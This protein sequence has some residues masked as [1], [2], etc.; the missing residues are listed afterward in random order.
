MIRLLPRPGIC[1]ALLTT[2]LASTL[3]HGHETVSRERQPLAPSAPA[4]LS[5]KLVAHLQF[6]PATQAGTVELADVRITQLVP[7]PLQ[8]ER[9]DSAGTS[10]QGAVRNLS[11]Q[12]RTFVLGGKRYHA[13]P[14][15]AVS[16]TLTTPARQTFETVK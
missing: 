3:T 1:V 10:I 14:G 7:H 5:E 16:F 15:E 2:F 9:L 6:D 13:D 4:I 11:R 12:A 8:F